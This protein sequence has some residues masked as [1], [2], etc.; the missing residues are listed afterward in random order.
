[1]ARTKQDAL[2]KAAL[3]KRQKIY[4]KTGKTAKTEKTSSVTVSTIARSTRTRV[5]AQ[6][7][8]KT[9]ENGKVKRAEK[10]NKSNVAVSARSTRAR[11]EA[12]VANEPD[13]NETADT[14]KPE[15]SVTG[16][17]C[18]KCPKS[19]ASQSNLN[20]HIKA[21]HDNG[22]GGVR[23]FVCPYCD[24]EQSSKYSHAR[25]IFRK[26]PNESVENLSE[27]ECTKTEDYC[28]CVFLY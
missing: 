24:E 20:Q 19:Y 14:N 8:N 27:N 6:T 10:G 9:G 15:V 16:F 23:R 12:Q 22:E 21:M 3:S 18:I 7:A 11:A 13:D 17:R 4:K 25:H 28:I 26:H 5:E 1:M 2:E